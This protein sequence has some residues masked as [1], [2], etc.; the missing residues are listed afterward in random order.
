MPNTILFESETHKNVLLEDFN[1]ASIAV[2]A[3]QHVIVDNKEAMILDPGGHKIYNQVFS[4]TMSLLNGGRLR[5]LFLSHQDPDIVAA[6]NGWL[7][8]TDAEAW[9][10][11]LWTRFVPHFG[12]D[13]LVA[14]RLH[15]VPDEGM[16]LPLGGC[17]LALLP[18]HFLHSCG[19]IQVYDPIAKILY[20]GDLGASIGNDDIYV[21]DFDAHVQYMDGFHRRY[22]A[23]KRVLQTWAAMARQLDIEIIAPQHGGLFKGKAMVERFVEWVSE[24]ECGIDLMTRFELPSRKS[25]AA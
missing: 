17:E 25:P 18:A 24:L 13:H 10:S 8:T 19:N 23:S 16:Y 11:A 3:N 14:D 1:S 2:Q 6:A 20:T 4:E 12:L 22:M 9:C 15:P 7:M 21:D 5:H